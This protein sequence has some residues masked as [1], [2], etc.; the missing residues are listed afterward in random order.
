M[1]TAN[2]NFAFSTYLGLLS[3]MSI[4]GSLHS[5]HLWIN[6]IDFVLVTA[7]NIVVHLN[8]ASENQS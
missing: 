5:H 2:D 3:R 4:E 8:H 7:P 1:Q 6:D